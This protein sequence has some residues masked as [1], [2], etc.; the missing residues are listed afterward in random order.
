MF[1]LRS[2][3]NIGPT[4]SP[5]PNHSLQ[6][7]GVNLKGPFR[8]S[9]LFGTQMSKQAT[10]GSIIN[11]S[12]TASI[13]PSAIE[14]PYA[15]AK[16]GLNNLT[17]SLAV[18]FGPKVRANCIVAGP[19]LTDISD[20]WDMEG[21]KK[22]A[23]KF[24]SRRG[25]QPHEVIGLA[26]Y[27]ASNAGAFQTGECIVLDGGTLAF[28]VHCCGNADSDAFFVNSRRSPCWSLNSRRQSCIFG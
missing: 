6:V 17:M 26:V 2:C 1:R 24:P 5:V 11:V 16:A 3:R 12:S 22:R 21:F 15:A 23:E 4:D 7:V 14:V 19:F 20:A 9:A 27:L 25:G 8:L 10:G 28:Y 18:T 13:K